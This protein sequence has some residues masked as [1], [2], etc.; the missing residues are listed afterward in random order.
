MASLFWS[1]FVF[2][3]D[4]LRLLRI[5]GAV[6]LAAAVLATLL[7]LGTPL[8][9]KKTH[10]PWLGFVVHP[11]LPQVLMAANKHILVMEVLQIM[12]EGQAMHAKEIEGRI[13]WAT[14]AC[15]LAKSMLQPLWAWKMATTTVGKPP[16]W[17]SC[18]ASSSTR[19]SDTRKSTLGIQGWGSQAANCGTGDRC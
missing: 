16:S 7:A 11:N 13:Q 8:S 1:N 17:P 9:W 2:V 3:D 6:N 18:C 10:R 14:S 4:F 19:P 5:K 12:V 15:P